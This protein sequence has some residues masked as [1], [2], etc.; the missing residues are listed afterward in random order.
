MVFEDSLVFNVFLSTVNHYYVLSA[1]HCFYNS[2][3]NNPSNV[4]A[5][6][7]EQ[8]TKTTAESKYTLDYPVIQIIIHSQYNPNGNLNDLSLVRVQGA[9]EWSIG[10]GPACLPY[11]YQST[12]FTNAYVTIA[13]FGSS[14]F[15]GPV[16]TVLQKATV[17]VDS[18][19]DCKNYYSTLVSS[20][21]CT[22]PQ[23]NSNADSCQ[24]DSGGP[25]YY[26]PQRQYVVGVIS[27]GL[28]CG[29]QKPSINTKVAS[30]LSW[31]E[32]NTGG[33]FCQK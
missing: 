14:S 7:G 32:S 27:S 17:V 8:D 4:L 33:G 9:I 23:Y 31:I 11:V 19:S 10:V 12:D 24:Y 18:A 22:K 21:M 13:G 6:V 2:V 5:R 28:Y 25:V 15:A 26:A 30:F 3:Y 29:T 1:A 20:Q 16:S